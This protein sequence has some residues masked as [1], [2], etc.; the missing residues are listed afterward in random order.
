MAACDDRR[1]P[2]LNVWDLRRASSPVSVLSGAHAGGIVG[3]SWCPHDPALLISAGNDGKLVCWNTQTVSD[4]MLT[5][6]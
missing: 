5:P 2:Y 1:Y 3:V 4:T 6:R